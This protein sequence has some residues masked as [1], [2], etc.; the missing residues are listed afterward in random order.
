MASKNQGES[1]LELVDVSTKKQIAKTPLAA[2]RFMPR[3]GERIFLPQEAARWKS[4]TV[5]S[6]E[7]F[8]G[9]TTH[10]EATTA[11]DKIVIYVEES[12]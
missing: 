2:I 7:Y 11:G 10:G 9:Q 6:V 4:Y 3:A 8:L 12:A 1:Y 5:I